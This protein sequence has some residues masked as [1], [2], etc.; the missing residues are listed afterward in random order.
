MTE[1]WE[2]GQH[3]ALLALAL[4]GPLKI[5]TIPPKHHELWSDGLCSESW[6]EEVENFFGRN[7]KVTIGF[8]YYYK[9]VSLAK[10]SM[11][12]S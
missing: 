12:E 9:P 2:E 1:A 11:S 10:S 4:T 5:L 6:L 7:L 3:V 8:Y